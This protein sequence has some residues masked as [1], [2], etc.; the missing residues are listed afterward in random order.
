MLLQFSVKNYRSFKEKAT[1][2]LIASNYDKEVNEIDNVY[3]NEKFGIRILK[4][5]AIYGAN[6]SGKT[7]LFEAL[8]FMKRLV[9]SSS[10]DTQLGDSIDVTP[11]AL[12]EETEHEPS[13]FEMIFLYKDTIYRYGFEVTKTEVVS[14][15]LYKRISTKESEIFY[16]DEDEIET[17]RVFSKGRTLIK[18]GLVRN[19]ALLI[20]VAAQFNDEITS[21]VIKW[22][23]NIRIIVV[24]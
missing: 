22:F 6:A 9:I 4:S 8:G 17:N 14:E 24:R 2:S 21:D 1:L 19:N 18:E 5:A 7:K 16:R 10:K 15:W 23:R 13:E 20:S 12:N 11:F 3:F